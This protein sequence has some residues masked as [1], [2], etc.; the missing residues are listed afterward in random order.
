MS[1]ATTTTNQAAIPNTWDKLYDGPDLALA[2]QRLTIERT[3]RRW[4][5][6][7]R[8]LEA[9]YPGQTLSSVELGAGGGDLSI[10]LAQLGHKVTLVDF[11][12]KALAHA[13]YRF[14]RLG[15][16]ADFI[17]ADLF[18]FMHTHAGR[19]DLSGS[20]GV[21]EH[22]SGQNR[23]DVIRAHQA[24]LRVGG[25]TFISVP[26]ARCVPYRLWKKYLELRDYWPYGYEAPF[27]PAS[28]KRFASQNGLTPKACYQ[29]GFSA[30]IDGC[31]ILPATGKRLGWRD[32]P[33]ALNLLGG[34]EANL[35]ATRD[36]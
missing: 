3:R 20:L 10:L 1:A 14:D 4:Q 13:S 33:R 11:S 2:D 21:A 32:G 19:F 15:L 18:E 25:T 24:V 17:Q 28:L 31:L 7:H 12:E 35:I 34:W 36:Q 27:S 26:N 29:T 23:H 5:T 9:T 30:S 16:S 22:F 8:Y 6:Y